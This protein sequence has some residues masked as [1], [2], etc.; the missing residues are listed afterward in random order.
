MFSFRLRFGRVFQ[1]R[2]RFVFLRQSVQFSSLGDDDLRLLT[3][4]GE[5]GELRGSSLFATTGHLT[6][7]NIL[8]TS[9]FTRAPCQARF[10]PSVLSLKLSKQA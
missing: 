9:S 2:F 3:G 6:S 10:T 7:E 4:L 8:F 1:H 5:D